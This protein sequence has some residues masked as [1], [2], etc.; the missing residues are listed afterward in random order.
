MAGPR[1][2][3]GGLA[4]GGG[5]GRGDKLT[6]GQRPIKDG[7]TSKANF[8][9]GTIADGFGV[10][11][12]DGSRGVHD[13]VRLFAVLETR[14]MAEFMDGLLEQALGADLGVI[15]GHQACRAEYGPAAADGGDAEYEGVPWRG[16][17]ESG[18]TE[19]PRVGRP[20]RNRRGEQ[21]IE[22]SIGGYRAAL[23]DLIDGDVQRRTARHTRAEALGQA[24]RQAVENLPRR[25][26]HADRNQLDRRRTGHS[27]MP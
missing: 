16:E 22:K 27:W 18:D 19:H 24:G 2:G 13:T 10:D 12:S 3:R 21:Q 9:S 23:R 7:S 26:R 5:G 25:F 15:T 1:V 11:L 17:V 14:D 4:N 6:A 8:A 20:M